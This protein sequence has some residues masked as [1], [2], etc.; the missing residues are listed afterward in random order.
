MANQLLWIADFA[1][2]AWLAPRWLKTLHKSREN[3][4]LISPVTFS[5]LLP[6]PTVDLEIKSS[7]S[8]T[9]VIIISS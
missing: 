2:V 3:L 6:R 5:S 7:N 9:A 8:G 4:P 1:G